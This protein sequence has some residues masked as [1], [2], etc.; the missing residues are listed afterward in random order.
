MSEK[1]QHLPCKVRANS[2]EKDAK[3]AKKDEIKRIKSILEPTLIQ[4]V[5]MNVTKEEFVKLKAKELGVDLKTLPKLKKRKRRS[6]TERCPTI[7]KN[8]ANRDC[9]NMKI[10]ATKVIRIEDLEHLSVLDPAWNTSPKKYLGREDLQ[11]L[12]LTRDPRGIANSRMDIRN[13]AARVDDEK[14]HLPDICSKFR[15]NTQFLLENNFENVEVVRYEDVV[16][17][18]FEE[19]ERILKI[20]GL[21]R[22]VEL[23]QYYNLNMAA[24]WLKV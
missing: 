8:M 14:K 18:P 17:R 5:K 1:D 21:E 2:F 23:T 12:Y 22:P 24:A 20:V 3:S 11:I 16:L 13:T 15:K 4:L 10:R 7:D 6:T 9:K 19:S